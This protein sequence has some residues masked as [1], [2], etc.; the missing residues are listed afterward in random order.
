M[1]TRLYIKTFGGF[2]I[3][4]NGKSV[5]NNV[6]HY[7]RYI[8]LFVYFVFNR[9]KICS[10]ETLLERLWPEKEYNNNKAA[11][12]TQI[13]RLK[14]QLAE[15]APGLVFK[16]DFTNG[17][18][19]FKL[20]ES[21]AEID[22][23]IFTDYFNRI[24]GFYEGGNKEEFYDLCR[25]SIDI[26]ES[27]LLN[28][29]MFDD[30]WIMP[31]KLLF[32]RMWFR[33]TELFINTCMCDERYED[34]I[35]LCQEVFKF[36][37]GEE[38]IHSSYM[39]ALWRAGYPR[40]AI[41]HYDHVAGH[42]N[43]KGSIKNSIRLKR[44]Y[45]EIRGEF[46]GNRRIGEDELKNIIAPVDSQI[47][48]TVC[49]RDDFLDFC[50]IFKLIS[51]R[52][53]GKPLIGMIE[54]INTGGEPGLGTIGALYKGL[55]QVDVIDSVKK[56]LRKSDLICKWNNSQILLFLLCGEEIE[57]TYVFDRVKDML[58]SM[59]GFPQELNLPLKM[60]VSSLS[61]DMSIPAN[62]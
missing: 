43:K 59:I 35:S 6:L 17:G 21:N 57:L 53:K 48:P 15:K 61:P 22:I 56:C 25:K 3:S 55:S 5:L 42:N 46:S 27:G 9:N 32:R 49:Y 54:I 31:Q 51:M 33:I 41:S 16:I 40:D 4:L 20:D 52:I 39:E 26:Y 19:I 24:I 30:E 62:Q 36:E 7:Q 13:F 11:L 14:R 44:L 23:N 8:K 50:R 34:I 1:D 28:E 18:Y 58:K 29:E 37:E 12:R 2:D 38:F 47:G 60:T 45:K 10:P